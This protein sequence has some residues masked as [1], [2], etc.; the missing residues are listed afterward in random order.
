MAYEILLV[1]P[2]LAYAVNEQG[3]TPLHL[4]ASKPSLFRSG[5]QLGW[6]KKIIYYC[7]YFS[8]V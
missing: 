1:E 6:W 7:K 8:I 3:R 4:L 2:S 5:S